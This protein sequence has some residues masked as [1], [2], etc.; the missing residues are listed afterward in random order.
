MDMFNPVSQ[1]LHQIM[2]FALTGFFLG[3]LY[4]PLRISRLFIKTGA[5]AV[6]IQDFLF[7][8]ACGVIVFAYSL[9]FGEGHFRYFYLIGIAFGA[10][11]YFLTAGK[12]I[13][14]ITRTFAQ[15]IKSIVKHIARAIYRSFVLPTWKLLVNIAQKTQIKS[16]N[17]HKS[18]K[19]HALH[20]KNTAVMKYN[21]KQ[22]YK[23]EKRNRQENH[24]G[25]K[26]TANPQELTK[27]PIKARIVKGAQK[28]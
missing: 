5:I 25:I 21:N 11:V 15:A 20:L 8:A 17:L 26:K 24:D 6:G 27:R 4:E 23:K 16:T 22:V 28:S 13:S 9:E 7:L 10:A 3:V 19:N 18:A 2:M 14:F 12:L 1:N